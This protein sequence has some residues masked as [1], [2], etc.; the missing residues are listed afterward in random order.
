MDCVEMR[1][2]RDLDQICDVVNLVENRYPAVTWRIVPGHFVW[3]VEPMIHRDRN[4]SKK[5]KL[6]WTLLGLN[7][8]SR[9]LH[10]VH[11]SHFYEIRL[12]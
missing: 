3:C 11:E 10:R 6:T 4:V 2:R 9:F 7:H 5:S 8:C 1:D 12:V